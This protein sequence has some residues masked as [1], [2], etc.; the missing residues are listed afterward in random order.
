[1]N[2]FPEW[3]NRDEREAAAVGSSLRKQWFSHTT[4]S[5]HRTG[6]D[7]DRCLANS[8][9]SLTAAAAAAPASWL[10]TLLVFWK[11]DDMNL[12][13]HFSECWQWIGCSVQNTGGGG[14]TGVKPSSYA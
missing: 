10:F 12:C 9:E 8:G 1:M 7:W 6:S 2:E 5:D 3:P 13:P 14:S 4:G 11:C